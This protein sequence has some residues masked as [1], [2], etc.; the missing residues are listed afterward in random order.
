MLMY[1]HILDFIIQT[2]PNWIQIIESETLRI[3]L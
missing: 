1:N 3:F 2:R